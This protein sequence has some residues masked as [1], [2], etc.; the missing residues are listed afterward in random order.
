LRTYTSAILLND[1]SIQ[2]VCY[3]RGTLNGLLENHGD[4][5]Q[6]LTK[7]ID[8]K[9]ED[10]LVEVYCYRGANFGAIG[11]FDM[12]IDDIRVAARAGHEPV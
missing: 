5:I 11:E 12:A 9:G 10:W 3:F 1:I 2:E 7:A 6:D 4:A 8:L